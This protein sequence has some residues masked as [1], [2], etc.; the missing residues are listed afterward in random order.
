M[1]LGKS[2]S[3]KDLL[4]FVNCSADFELLRFCDLRIAFVKAAQILGFRLG[5]AVGRFVFSGQCGNCLLLEEGSEVSIRT[6]GLTNS[7][8]EKF[9][10]LLLSWSSDSQG[11]GNGSQLRLTLT[12]EEIP[13]M[14][15]TTREMVS[16]LFSEF[17]KSSCCN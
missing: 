8:A 10:K 6:L 9:A 3:A 12:H 7:P 16:R 4:H 5:S 13:E 14:I 1:H 11:A 2:C 15:G 17:K